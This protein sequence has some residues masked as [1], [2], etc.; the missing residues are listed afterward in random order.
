MMKTIPVGSRLM[1]DLCVYIYIHM[2]MYISRYIRCM[3]PSTYLPTYLSI[4]LSIYLP[5]CLSLSLC[6]SPCLSVYGSKHVFSC[7]GGRMC[8][9]SAHVEGVCDSLG[10]LW[11]L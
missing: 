8:L 7:G 6:P 2:Y 5:G 10:V 9:S 1:L 4:Y 11:V 3:Y